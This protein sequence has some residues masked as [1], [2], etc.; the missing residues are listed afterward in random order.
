MFI[1]GLVEDEQRRTVKNIRY[2][3]LRSPP[4]EQLLMKVTLSYAC[5]DG[6][7]Y[8]LSKKKPFY[9]NSGQYDQLYLV[10]KL[11]EEGLASAYGEQDEDRLL[12][13]NKNS[14][15]QYFDKTLIGEHLVF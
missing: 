10:K 8:R 14:G 9:P 1:K 12:V 4:T 7:Y 11:Q 6:S 13:S 15:L 2:F 3:N 5:D